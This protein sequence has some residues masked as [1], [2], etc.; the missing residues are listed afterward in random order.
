MARTS[1]DGRF[2][3]RLSRGQVAA[4]LAVAGVVLVGLGNEAAVGG[5]GA[6]VDEATTRPAEP[7]SY[8][9]ARVTEPVTRLTVRPPQADP[10]AGVPLRLSVPHLGIET[11]VRHIE[12]EDGILEPPADASQ[13][14]WDRHTARAGSAYGSTVITGHTV[15]AGGGALDELDDLRRGDTV[16]VSTARGAI[17]YRVT[18]VTRLSKRAMVKHIPQ[19][20]SPDTLGRLVLIT[21]TDWNGSVYLSNTVVFATPIAS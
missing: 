17:S 13:V 20:F 5:G 2:P 9:V 6:T 15:H 4:V 10:A 11:S 7:T 18:T 12:V 21:C 3:F 14:G 16:T 1:T 8:D 19:V